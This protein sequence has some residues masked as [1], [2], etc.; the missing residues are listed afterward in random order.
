MLLVSVVTT[1]YWCGDGGKN[2]NTA[3]ALTSQLSS[4]LAVAQ[5][6]LTPHHTNISTMVVLDD[7][8]NPEVDKVDEEEEEEEECSVVESLTEEEMMTE[9]SE[10]GR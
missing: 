10:L 4:D 2:T 9:R 1:I 3:A 7:K 5:C 8:H 6:T